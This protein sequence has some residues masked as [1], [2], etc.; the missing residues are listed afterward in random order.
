MQFF[1]ADCLWI[2][3]PYREKDED[4]A[5]TKKLRGALASAL[6]QLPREFNVSV[7]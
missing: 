4:D 5:E 1:V 2:Y 6:I 7:S 3:F